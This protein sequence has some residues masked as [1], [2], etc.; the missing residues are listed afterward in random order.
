MIMLGTYATGEV[1]FK[2]VYLTGIVRDKQ[3]RKMSKSLGNSPDPLDLIAKYGADGVR[4]GM[5]LSSPA[6]NDLLFDE[7][8]CEQGR[9]FVN[10]IWNAFRLIKG[11]AVDP[12]LAQNKTAK[13]AGEWFAA[14]MAS[15]LQLINVSYDQYR[16]SET[17]MLTYKL[18][19]DDFCAWY[20]EMIKPNFA[21]GVAQPIDALTYAQ[22]TGFL[23]AL[24]QILHP[25]TP[26]ITEELW[27]ELKVREEH[28]AIIISSWPKVGNADEALI[29]DF[30]SFAALIGSIRA[31][32]QEKGIS[33]KQG[34]QLILNNVSPAFVEKWRALLTKLG[35]LDE[36]KLG[37]SAPAHSVSFLA[38]TIQGSVP[39]G[40]FIDLSLEREKIEKELA[41]TK[42][43][44]QS[45]LKKLENRGFVEKAAPALI[46]NEK[47]KQEDAE[48]KIKSLEQQLASMG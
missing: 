14:K 21:D 38:G 24:L 45:V 31:V 17:L 23:E 6:G 40:D 39:V 12:N 41:Y 5:L 35:G 16:I 3:G 42:G 19:W 4:V 2:N 28:E 34:L 26:F 37:E 7:S 29:K 48:S 43:F 30:E 8:S 33:P 1:P 20:L 44:L 22:A 10:K 18:I 25:F 32:R 9:N 27:H 36:I 15:Q 11:F 13:L 46:A 47:K